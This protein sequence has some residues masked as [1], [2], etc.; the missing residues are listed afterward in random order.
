ML[1]WE[2]NNFFRDLTY[3]QGIYNL[4]EFGAII[5]KHVIVLND[6]LYYVRVLVNKLN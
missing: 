3:R 4:I 6:Y 5:I 1:R 2:D